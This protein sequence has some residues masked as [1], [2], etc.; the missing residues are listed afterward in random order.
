M[1]ALKRG[2]PKPTAIASKVA[3]PSGTNLMPFFA[4]SCLNIALKMQYR[5]G[6]EQMYAVMIAGITNM[7]A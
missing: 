5:V 6:I 7:I 1:I 2:I 4:K 3:I